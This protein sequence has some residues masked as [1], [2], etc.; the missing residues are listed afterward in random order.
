MKPAHL[1]ILFLGTVAALQCV[2]AQKGPGST[3]V[4]VEQ[5]STVITF[6]NSGTCSI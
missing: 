4:P 1:A 5:S 3:G 2:A 6:Y